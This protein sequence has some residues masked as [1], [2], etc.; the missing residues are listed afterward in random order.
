MPAP[1]ARSFSASVP[2]GVNCRSSSP[3]SAWRSNSLFSHI[4]G[5]D[6]PYLAR[7]EEQAHTEIVDA[8][9]VADDGEAFDAA[10]DQCLDEILRDPAQ[11]EA[12]RGDRHV[13]A[14]QPLERRGGVWIYLFH[15]VASIGRR[16]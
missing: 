11:P 13:V 1:P 2:C 6:L 3:A 7:L 8:R 9:I 12:A 16:L 4:G 15:R 5:D 14:Q 10:T